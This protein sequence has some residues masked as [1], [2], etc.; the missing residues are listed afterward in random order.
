MLSGLDLLCLPCCCSCSSS[1]P[2]PLALQTWCVFGPCR[3]SQLSPCLFPAIPNSQCGGKEHYCW[4]DPASCKG[5]WGKP[6]AA[7]SASFSPVREGALG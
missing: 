5:G 1:V 4:G 6:L 2:F 7:L 3:L